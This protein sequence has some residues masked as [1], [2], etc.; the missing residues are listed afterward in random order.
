MFSSPIFRD[1]L[2][3]DNTALEKFCRSKCTDSKKYQDRGF[4]Q[5]D[6]LDLTDPA[7]L[8][9]VN[10]I[11]NQMNMLHLDLGLSE[12]FQS[13]LYRGWANLDNN[14]SIRVPHSHPEATFACVYYVTGNPESG[15]LEFINPNLAQSRTIL[16]KHVGTFNE[17]T[18]STFKINPV[19]GQLIIFPAW[20][21]H[22]VNSGIGN[23]ERISIAFDIKIIAG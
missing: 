11:Q 8:E 19:P 13:C 2:D 15:N 21:Y 14:W 12:N 22:Y 17:F 4:S 9:L 16:P 3:L 1:F 5:S 6:D 23:N 20:L 7:L 10:T 18:G